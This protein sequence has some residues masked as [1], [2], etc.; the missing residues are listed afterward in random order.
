MSYQLQVK[1]SDDDVSLRSSDNYSRQPAVKMPELEPSLS[2]PN[3]G[4]KCHVTLAT[5]ADPCLKYCN[6]DVSRSH[7][8]GPEQDVWSVLRGLTFARKRFRDK[9]PLPNVEEVVS[10]TKKKTRLGWGQGLAKYEKEK[11][12]KE[13]MNASAIG[14]TGDSTNSSTRATEMVACSDIVPAFSCGSVS[15]SQDGTR[16]LLT[17]ATYYAP[18]YNYALIKSVIF[19]YISHWWSRQSWPSLR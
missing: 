10:A 11:R 16:K 3:T 2:P 5:F 13:L 6:V 18:S 14:V 17:L 12:E 15:P 8:D 7:S 19:S 4:L 1:G 9:N